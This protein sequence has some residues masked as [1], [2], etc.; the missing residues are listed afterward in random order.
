MEEIDFFGVMHHLYVANL[1]KSER[2]GAVSSWRHQGTQMRFPGALGGKGW[3]YKGR[4]SSEAA[5][6]TLHIHI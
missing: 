1:L 3:T 5:R 6:A 2:K 4:G